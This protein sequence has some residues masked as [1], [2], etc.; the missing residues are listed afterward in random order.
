M[1]GRSLALATVLLVTA[2]SG[3][4][5]GST[6]GVVHATA[7]P[8]TGQGAQ[9]LVA[10]TF[11]FAAPATTSASTRSPKYVTANIASIKIALNTVNGGAPPAG[12]TASVTTNI[13]LASCPC[14]VSGPAV[15]PGNDTF[16]LTAYDAQ[17]GGGNVVSTATPTLTILADQPN[18]NT[19]TLN[20]V[21]A[22][23]TISPPSGTAGTAFASATAF[24]V[25]VKDAD[26]NTIMGIYE[27]PVTLADGDTSG[28]TTLA[29]SGSDSP[30]AGE[31]LSSS[32]VAKLNYTGLAIAPVVISAAA[33]GATTGNGSFAPTL[34]PIVVTTGDAQNPSFAGV[35]FYATSGAGSSGS[36]TISEVGWTNAPYNKTL[37]VAPGSGCG[38]IGSVVQTGSSFAATVAGSPSAGACTVVTLSDGLGQSQAV[39]LAYTAFAYTGASQSIT[40]PSGVTTVTVAST[41]AEGGAADFG[42][43]A[44]DGGSV[45]ATIPVTAGISLSVFVGG[46]GGVSTGTAGGAAGYNGGAAGGFSAVSCCDGGGGGG[47]SGVSISGTAVVVAGGGGGGGVSGSGSTG[48]AGGGSTAANGVAGAGVPSPGGGGGGGTTSGSGGSG[49]SAGSA[50]GGGGIAGTAGATGSGGAG[51]GSGSCFDPSGGGGGG[52]YGGG[53]GGCSTGGGGGGG[54]GGSSF[55][56]ASATNVTNTQGGQTGNGAIT[57]SW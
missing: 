44:G 21:P 20:G 41:G 6:P 38:S 40:V 43:A 56:E 25:T 29:T 39:T 13:A 11:V 1:F 36:F 8:A 42:I 31:L 3:G 50:G 24:S 14:T 49:G 35:D 15:P 46:R 17:N 9:A 37:T 16:T 12:V 55:I 48:G 32:D 19:I 22:S 47:A 18:N 54:G 30:P 7:A 52:Y 4:G 28:A 33:T 53:G 27:S 23:F 45:T 10:T 2:C 5:G 26:G 51:A 34:Q 57:I